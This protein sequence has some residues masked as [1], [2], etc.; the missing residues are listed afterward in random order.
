VKG[1]VSISFQML[2]GVV[3]E[4]DY[5]LFV[6][7]G[8]KKNLLSISSMTYVQW[9]DAFEGQQCTISDCNLASLR[10]LDS[11]VRDGGLYRLLANPVALVHSSERLDEPF[12][13]EEAYVEHAWWDVMETGSKP[14]IDAMITYCVNGVILLQLIGLI[15]QHN[16]RLW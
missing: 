14:I 16:E 5:V 13:F 10:T 15:F 2:L 8:L 3:L 7:P 6:L 4:L 12:S 9:R 11:G 1:V